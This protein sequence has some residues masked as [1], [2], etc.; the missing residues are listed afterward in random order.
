MSSQ[1]CQDGMD[2][3]RLTHCHWVHYQGSIHEDGMA[4]STILI[5]LSAQ[6][7]LIAFS[8]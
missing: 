7:G 2:F 5:Q 6:E 4:Y 1:P 8:C 3:E